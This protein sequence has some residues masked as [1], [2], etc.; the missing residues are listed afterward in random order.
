M[1]GVPIKFLGV[2]EKTDALEV[3]HPDRLA[4]RILGMGDML[5]AIEKAQQVVDQEQALKMGQKLAKGSLTW[6][7]FGT[8]SSS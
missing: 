5:T 6:R 2:G 7:I 4:S 1:T 8:S 3:F